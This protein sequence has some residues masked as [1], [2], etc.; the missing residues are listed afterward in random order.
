MATLFRKRIY[1]HWHINYRFKGRQFRVSTGTAVK[2]LEAD[3]I[4]G[5]HDPSPQKLQKN[6]IPEFFRR[7]TEFSKT[8]KS[9]AT[10]LSDKYRF[11]Q[12]QE[13]FAREGIKF[14]EEISPSKIQQFQIFILSDYNKRLYNN[15]LTLLKSMLNK[16]VEWEII[17]GNPIKS[18][19]PLKTPKI[20]RY[21]S[22]EEIESLQTLAEPPL[23]L[24]LDIAIY[25]GLRRSELYYIRW[26]DID[27]K[28]ELI[29]V[30]AHGKFVPKNKKPG[31]VPINPKLLESLKLVYPKDK[32]AD[33]DQYVFADFHNNH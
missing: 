12:L 33:L 23:D 18:C 17:K 15:F 2:K 32:K 20:I 27:L 25:A 22:L 3:I 31:T 19:K 26:K 7:Y 1:G 24:L 11:K 29:H 21:F 5:I 13:Y 4:R 16:A 30:R 28:Q 9:S 14:L 6:S 10:H 8:T